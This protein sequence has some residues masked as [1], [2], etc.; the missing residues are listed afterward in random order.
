MVME[1]L[2]RVRIFMIDV[3]VLCD[4]GCL[5]F[6]CSHQFFVDAVV[7]ILCLL[8]LLF[9]YHIIIVI[10]LSHLLPLFFQDIGIQQ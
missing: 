3:C 5:L 4:T 9:L 6:F 10:F 7:G 1:V 8:L 2:R